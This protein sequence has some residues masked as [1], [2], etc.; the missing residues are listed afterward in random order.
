MYHISVFF[1]KKRPAQV[2]EKDYMITG[3]RGVGGVF[4]KKKKEK[5]KGREGAICK[6]CRTGREFANS[7]R[8]KGTGP[9]DLLAIERK[10]LLPFLKFCFVFFFFSFCQWFRANN[11]AILSLR[12]RMRPCFPNL[13]SKTT[14]SP[15]P[16]QKKESVVRKASEIHFT[17]KMVR[18]LEGPK[19]HPPHPFQA[20]PHALVSS[21]RKFHSV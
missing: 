16:P 17:L 2:N 20:H 11:F 19:K 3:V 5:K 8:G 7:F 4:E 13:C 10:K 21:P 15:P 18:R 1:L 12:L 6:L 14:L 9:C